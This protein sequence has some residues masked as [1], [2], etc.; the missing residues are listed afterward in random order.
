[1]SAVTEYMTR[2][3][4]LGLENGRFPAKY[5]TEPAYFERERE[6]I[7]RRVWLMVGRVE[8]VAGVGDYIVHENPTLRASVVIVRGKDGEVRAFH[9]SCSHRGVALVCQLKGTASSFRC[10]YHGWLYGNDGALRGVPSEKDFPHVE[11]AAN[12]LTPVALEMWNGFIFLNFSPVPDVTLREYLAGLDAVLDGMPFQDYPFQ[13]KIRGD[14]DSN[15]KFLVNA[16]NEGYHVGILHKKTLYPQVIPPENPFL[17]YLDIRH[18]GPH[19]MGT[20][21]RNFDWSPSTPVLSWVM[22]QMLP[23]SVPDKEALAA[24]KVGLTSH[25]GINR[26]KVPN[27]GT[28]T[29]TIFPN[30]S[31]QPLANGY[32]FYQF[33]PLSHDR[34]RTEVRIYGKHAPRSLREEFA[35]ANT[36]A[37][38]RDVV[39]EDMAM[40]QRQQIGVNGG[41]KAFQTFGENESLLRLFARDYLAYLGESDAVPKARAAK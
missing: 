15:W 6:R 22:Q 10:P 13:I 23:T 1:M 5:Y 35:A 31:I 36:L 19:S 12:G 11:K 26:I 20:V 16:F 24:G 2:A 7:F 32:L 17:H 4:D 37:A 9:N 28:E 18:Y 27:F 38:T 8:E 39:S 29:I 3:R 34:M 41:G 40:S 25:A 33:W 30:I 14:I 21:Q